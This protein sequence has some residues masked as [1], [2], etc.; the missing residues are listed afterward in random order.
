MARDPLRVVVINSSVR[1]GRF[2]PTAANW[3]LGQAT[4]RSDMDVDYLDLADH[5]LP[6]RLS[7]EPSAEVEQ[8][9]S[10]W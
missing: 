6:L 8:A 7:R 4:E 9:R 5:P 1:D 3:F 10:W 2:G